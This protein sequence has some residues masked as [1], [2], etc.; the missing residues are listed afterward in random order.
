MG[1]ILTRFLALNSS[2]KNN[3]ATKNSKTKFGLSAGIPRSMALLKK[4]N[5]K[6][7]M[8][9]LKAKKIVN[10]KSFLSQQRVT[11]EIKVKNKMGKK[12]L[13]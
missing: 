11:L 4:K 10:Y 3:C 7:L 1:T 5:K 9:N 6:Q 13:T 8:N 12:F 2:R